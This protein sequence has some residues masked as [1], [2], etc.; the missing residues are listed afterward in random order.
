MVNILRGTVNDPTISQIP[1]PT[2]SV[3]SVQL[4]VDASGMLESVFGSK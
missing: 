1:D 2:T 3:K 4:T